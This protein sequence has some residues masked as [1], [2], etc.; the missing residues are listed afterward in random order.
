MKRIFLFLFLASSMLHAQAV[1][2]ITFTWSYS[3]TPIPVC[4]TTVMSNCISSYVLTEG[5]NTLAQ[6][7]AT[8]ATSYTYNLAPL[9]AAGTHTYTLVAVELLTGTSTL[10]SAPATVS[11]QVPQTP[12]V[13]AN[14]TA[15]PQ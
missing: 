3:Y 6:V 1:H 2:E 10:N 11:L 14:F 5:N 8:S 7:Q 13:P 9:P 4:S 12:A 15:T